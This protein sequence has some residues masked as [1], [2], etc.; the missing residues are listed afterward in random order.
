MHAGFIGTQR[1]DLDQRT[2]DRAALNMLIGSIVDANDGRVLVKSVR[3]TDRAWE[4][5]RGLLARP[6][7]AAGEGLLIDPCASVHTCFM[8]YAI[9]V[10]YLDR[11]WQVL[12]VVTAL[13]PWRASYARGAA[14]TLEL[15][16]GAAATLGIAVGHRLA[17]RPAVTR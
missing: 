3:R 8:G 12:R 17:W 9:D 16:P 10:V 13:A 4:R 1:T 15:A 5:L 14:L 6:C 7:P 2:H 11:Q